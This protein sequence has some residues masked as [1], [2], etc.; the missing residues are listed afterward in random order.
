MNDHMG[1]ERLQNV[2]RDKAVI[3]A[4]ILVFLELWELILANVHH[5]CDVYRGLAIECWAGSRWGERY[6]GTSRGQ[7][8]RDSRPARDS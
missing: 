8:S 2:A 3:D 6:R 7:I 5:G 4:G 1:V